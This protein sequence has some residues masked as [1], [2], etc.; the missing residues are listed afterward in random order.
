MVKL[1]QYRSEQMEKKR[2]RITQLYNQFF[3]ESSSQLYQ[4]HQKLDKLVMKIYGFSEEDDILER[5]LELNLELAEKEKREDMV[6]IDPSLIPLK[7]GY[8]KL[9]MSKGSL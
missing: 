8:L 5:L 3:N 9:M 4:L 6:K 2:W 1:H 7:K